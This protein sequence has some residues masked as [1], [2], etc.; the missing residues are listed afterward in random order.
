MLVAAKVDARV[1]APRGAVHQHAPGRHAQLP[2]RP[3]LQPLVHD[4]GRAG[5]AAR[6]RRHARRDR[7]ARPAPSRSASSRRSSSSRSAWTSRWRAA[8]TRSAAAGEAAEPLELDPIELTEEDIAT[9]APRRARCRS[10]R[11]PTRPPPSASACRRTRCS[12]GWPRCKERGGLRR[13][14]AIL[15]HRRAGFSANGMG[16]WAVPEPEILDTGKRMAAFRGISHCYQR[17]TYADWP[18]SVF[19]MAHG[20][21]KEECDAI[22][23]SIAA[24]HGIERARDALLEHRVQEGADALLHRRVQALGGGARKRLTHLALRHALGGA[25]RAA[26]PGSC[27]A[28]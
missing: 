11:S 1:P 9:S 5:L 13:V 17:P 8:P 24:P 19:T 4:R 14:A 16:V 2:A 7:G 20:R 18:Y 27:P 23:D 3:R 26:P 22:L 15:Y 12:S 10:S 21:S 6:P 25:L 28:A